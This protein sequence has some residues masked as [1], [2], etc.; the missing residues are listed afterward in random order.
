MGLALSCI[1]ESSPLPVVEGRLLS[2]ETHVVEGRLYLLP[3]RRGSF[4]DLF[5][6]LPVV[7]G[8]SVSATLHS[9]TLPLPTRGN[10]DWFFSILADS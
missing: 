3:C 4:A 5:E 10:P 9:S 1:R 2:V 8:V 6:P 7:D